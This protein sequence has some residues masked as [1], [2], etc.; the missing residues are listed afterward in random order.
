MFSFFSFKVIFSFSFKVIL[1]PLVFFSTFS[2]YNQQRIIQQSLFSL[3][4]NLVLDSYFPSS[5]PMGAYQLSINT[6][7]TR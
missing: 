5:F 3:F 1:D 7:A 6:I 2:Y 4:I